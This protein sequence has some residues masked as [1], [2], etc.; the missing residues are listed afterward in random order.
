MLLSNLAA[1]DVPAGATHGLGALREAPEDYWS[2]R[3]QLPWT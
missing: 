1:V 3:S 2:A